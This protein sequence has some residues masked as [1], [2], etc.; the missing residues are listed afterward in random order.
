M[1]NVGVRNVVIA[2]VIGIVIGII[3]RGLKKIFNKKNISQKKELFV[4]ECD[5]ESNE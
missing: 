3:F 1:K 5:V 4:N 2:I